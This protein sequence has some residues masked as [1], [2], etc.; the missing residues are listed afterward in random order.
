MTDKGIRPL[1]IVEDDPGLQSQLRWCFE[2]YDVHIAGDRHATIEYI[3]NNSAPVVTL[4]LGLPPDPANVSEGFRTL[5][6]ILAI[7]P[8]TKVIVVTGNDDQ[9][10]AVRA[11]GQGAYDFYQKPVD[12]EVLGLIVNRAYRLH[13][14]EEQNRRLQVERAT[15]IL[16]GLIANSTSMQEVRKVIEKVAPTS[17]STLLL[18]ESGTGKELLAHALHDL[19]PRSGKKFIAINCAAIPENLLE[20]ELFGYEKGAFTGAHKRTVGKFE[21][22]NGGTLLLDEIGDLPMS[23]QAKLLRFLQERVIE[24]IG[25]REEIPVD[26]RVVCATH[27]DLNELIEAGRFREDLFYR[28]SEVVIKIPPLREREGDA[29]LIARFLADNYAGEQGKIAPELTAE[30]M[31]VIEKHSWPGNI[32]ELANRIK[33]AVIMCEKNRITSNDL[34]LDMVDVTGTDMSLR[35]VR[36]KAEIKAIIRALSMSDGNISQAAKLL[37]VSRPTLYDM[38]NRFELNQS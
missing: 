16:P 37:G 33:R 21:L 24:R 17:V 34:E 1:L 31:S 36:E 20:S 9:A 3:S 35:A 7:K 26:V 13:E 8:D 23:L 19:S 11:I 27:Q 18:G 25:G 30:A 5:E 14:L 10:N 29:V 28:I 15:T 4:D 6:E 32:R 22:A 12:P 2:D 38:I